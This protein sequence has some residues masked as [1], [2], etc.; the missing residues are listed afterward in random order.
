M[1]SKKKKQVTGVSALK[2]G[3]ASKASDEAMK[4]GVAGNE[5]DQIFSRGK[6][7]RKPEETAEEE[8]EQEADVSL[9]RKTRKSN[10]K[11]KSSA[12]GKE[13][14]VA[15][16]P[17]ASGPRKRTNEGFSLYTEEELSWNVK[18]A[19]GTPLCP[20]DCNCCF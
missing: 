20:F 10:K 13:E 11:Q 1:G 6:A 3:S 18:D 16:A 8:G 17:L 4:G 19:G 9:K 14:S 12:P 7:K 2:A 5:I 15:K